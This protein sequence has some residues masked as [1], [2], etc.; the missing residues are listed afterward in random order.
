[1][2][3]ALEAL[4]ENPP[5]ETARLPIRAHCA[6]IAD[7]I[8]NTER[9]SGSAEEES[10]RLKMLEWLHKCVH[11][12]NPPIFEAVIT[13]VRKIGLMVEALEILQRGLVKRDEFPPA[14]WRLEAHRMRYATM[15]GDELVLGQV[16]PVQV[17][18]VNMERQL[19]DFRIVEDTAR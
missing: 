7:H 13:D 18:R 8:S 12:S 6:E 16:V 2:H 15:H 9:T 17:A 1:M 14:D 5:R 11:E 4:L 3:R 19:V 10:R